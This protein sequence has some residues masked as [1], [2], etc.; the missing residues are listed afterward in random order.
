[1]DI[2]DLPSPRTLEW[3]LAKKR[4]IEHEDVSTPWDRTSHDTSRILEVMMF[5]SAVGGRAYTD[6]NHRF[7]GYLDLSGHL[8]SG[9]AILLGRAETPSTELV[10]DDESLEDH[11]D[12]RYAFYRIMA[13]VEAAGRSADSSAE[14]SYSE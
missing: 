12:R 13:P 5:H 8:T 2:D 1:V 3:T 10:R 7:Q 9:R 4:I 14:L 6:L 11:Y